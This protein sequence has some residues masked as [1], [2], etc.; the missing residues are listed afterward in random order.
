ME[1]SNSF[2]HVIP[3]PVAPQA[4][5]LDLLS[6]QGFPNYLALMSLFKTQILDL[7]LDNLI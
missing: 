2:M 7:F 1:S 6:G 4:L 5:K 3:I